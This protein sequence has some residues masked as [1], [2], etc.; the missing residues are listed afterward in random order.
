MEY[1]GVSIGLT[2]K[3]KFKAFCLI[4]NNGQVEGRLNQLR[5]ISF[6][7]QPRTGF[8][9]V[10]EAIEYASGMTPDKLAQYID[11]G[12]IP[13]KGVHVDQQEYDNKYIYCM[14]DY[15][16]STDQWIIEENDQLEFDFV[17]DLA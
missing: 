5:A 1:A 11:E 8:S 13:S 14:L 10:E 12:K 3:R 2:R 6:K 16:Y 7:D 9:T 17:K 4:S 15:N